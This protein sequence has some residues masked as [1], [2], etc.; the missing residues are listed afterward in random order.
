MDLG[1]LSIGPHSY[2]APIVQNYPGDTGKVIIG[3]FAAIA[4]GVEMWTGGNHPTDWVS[5]YPFRI[6]FQ[7]P[8]ALT[9]GNPTGKGNVVVGSDVW[10]GRGARVLSGV[11]IGHGAVVGAYAVVAKDV[12]PYAIVV[13]NPAREVRRRFTD[14]QV[15]ALLEIAWWDWP[16]EKVME[17]VPWMSNA[18]VDGFIA[19][20][21]TR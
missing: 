10:V 2:G 5:H 16:I 20:W 6:M 9:D 8:G 13:G 19:R 1:L 21:G 15:N 18:D 3:S 14:D 4:E 12:R 7:L 17:A 11:H